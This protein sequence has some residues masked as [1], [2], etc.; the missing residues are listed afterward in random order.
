MAVLIVGVIHAARGEAA[1]EI[2][3]PGTV[4]PFIDAPIYARTTGYLR[5]G[6]PTSG[7]V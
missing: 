3:L 2:T 5:S 7:R 4:Q 6:T 1:Q